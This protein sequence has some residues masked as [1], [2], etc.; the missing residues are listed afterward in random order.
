M[1]D[2]ALSPLVSVLLKEPYD[3]RQYDCAQ[4]GDTNSVDRAAFPREAGTRMIQ[5]PRIA[6]TIPTMMSMKA[7]KPGPFIIFPVIQAAIRPAM[8]HQRIKPES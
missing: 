7:P 6:P 3:Q 1:I 8:T 5:P 4:D 2:K